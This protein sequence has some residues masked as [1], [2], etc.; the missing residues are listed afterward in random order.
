MN[1]LPFWT[2]NGRKNRRLLIHLTL[3]KDV[4]IFMA[5][6]QLAPAQTMKARI[7]SVEKTPICLPMGM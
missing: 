3:E 4:T 6:H 2:L 5:S 7:I 1:L